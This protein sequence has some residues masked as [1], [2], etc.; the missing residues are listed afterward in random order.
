M[1][2]LSIYF[3]TICSRSKNI[4]HVASALVQRSP[5]RQQHTTGELIERSTTKLTTGLESINK[6]A[7]IISA[8]CDGHFKITCVL[9]PGSLSNHVPPSST[10]WHKA[11]FRHD[12]KTRSSH[13]IALTRTSLDIPPRQLILFK[14]INSREFAVAFYQTLQLPN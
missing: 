12:R 3:S 11:P 10:P 5:G 4:W 6:Q 9:R 8:I 13:N 1:I 14:L 7:T 2:Y